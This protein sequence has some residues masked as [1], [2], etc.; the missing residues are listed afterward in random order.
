MKF[1]YLNLKFDF[2]SLTKSNDSGYRIV[3]QVL[4][5]I[6]IILFALFNYHYLFV[7]RE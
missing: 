1:Q 5:I 7:P 4:L 3:Q 6:I 2:L